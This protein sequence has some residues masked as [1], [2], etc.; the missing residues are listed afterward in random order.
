M[1]SIL[2]DETAAGKLNFI[3]HWIKVVQVPALDMIQVGGAIHCLT[4][5]IS[6]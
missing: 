2:V 4:M 3:V 5:Q 6:K 1:Q